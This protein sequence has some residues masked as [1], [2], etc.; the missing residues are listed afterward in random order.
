MSNSTNIVHYAFGTGAT[1][2][3]VPAAI[4]LCIRIVTLDPTVHISVMIHANHESSVQRLL[5]AAPQAQGRV[6]PWMVG[7]KTSH[8]EVAKAFLDMAYKSGSLYAQILAVSWQMSTGT[9]ADSVR[10]PPCPPRAC[11]SST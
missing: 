4:K 5:A 6:K 1:Y 3:H 7:E 2:S 9:E 11:S 10:T 8:K